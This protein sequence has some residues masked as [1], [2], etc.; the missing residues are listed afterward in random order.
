MLDESS[1]LTRILYRELGALNKLNNL[2][3][4]HSAHEL[5][6]EVKLLR[7]KVKLN[8]YLDDTT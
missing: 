1:H 4:K 5:L 7:D 3:D 2:P 6:K 8:D